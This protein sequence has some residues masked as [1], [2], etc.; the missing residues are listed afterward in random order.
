MRDD[1]GG[2]ELKVARDDAQRAKVR[3]RRDL[4]FALWAADQLG[5]G[6]S[7]AQDYAVEMA[8]LSLSPTGEVA[9]LKKVRDDL[10]SAGKWSNRDHV[11]AE[12]DAAEAAAVREVR[13][14]NA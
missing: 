1:G 2:G 11:A 5:L 3:A 9:M 6:G 7:A 10:E 8:V 14:L 12:L 4:I 13:R